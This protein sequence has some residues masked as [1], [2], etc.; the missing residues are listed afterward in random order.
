MCGG[1]IAFVRFDYTGSASG[2]LSIYGTGS[3]DC[4]AGHLA[5]GRVLTAALPLHNSDTLSAHAIQNILIPYPFELTGEYPSLPATIPAGGNLSFDISFDLPFAGSIGGTPT[6]IVTAGNGGT[7]TT[8]AVGAGNGSGTP[9]PT[10]SPWETNSSLLPQICG[11]PSFQTLLEQVGVENFT[12]GL[13]TGP[14]W[15]VVYPTF[16]WVG[17]CGNSTWASYGPQCENQEFWAA[18]ITAGTISGPVHNEGPLVTEC[19]AEPAPQPNP[20][21]SSPFDYVLAWVVLAA[22]AAIVGVVLWIRFRPYRPLPGE[23]ERP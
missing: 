1:I 12:W 15:V 7:A 3:L 13:A 21:L 6:A 10:P 23:T 9:C 4:E 18:N 11:E 22:V 5:P 8:D 19:C 16:N 20:P 14:T 2:Y 17:S